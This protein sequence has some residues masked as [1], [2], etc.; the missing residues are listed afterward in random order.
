MANEKK[1]ALHKK[2]PFCLRDL[3]FSTLHFGLKVSVSW[4]RKSM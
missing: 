4:F 1:R 2:W 3:F